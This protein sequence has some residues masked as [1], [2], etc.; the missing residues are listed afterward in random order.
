MYAKNKFGTLIVK[1]SVT[2]PALPSNKSFSRM[3]DGGLSWTLLDPTPLAPNLPTG[4]LSENQTNLRVYPTAVTNHLTIEGAENLPV[5]IYDLM[6]TLWL[7]DFNT[8]TTRSIDLSDLLT[9]IYLV[10]IGCHS[11]KIV[12]K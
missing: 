1:D 10:K 3:G 12:K 2:F 6:G 7:S 11:F 5:K 9:G 8:S 4:L